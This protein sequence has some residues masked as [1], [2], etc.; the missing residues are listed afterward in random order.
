MIDC[1]RMCELHSNTV[2]II[3]CASYDGDHG[4]CLQ[5]V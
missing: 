5:F 4:F 2:N 3:L 1:T